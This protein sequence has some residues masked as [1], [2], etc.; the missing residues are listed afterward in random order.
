MTEESLGAG[1]SSRSGTEVL[2]R[3]QE[4]LNAKFCEFQMQ[5]RI[6]QEHVATTHLPVN[7]SIAENALVAYSS[8]IAS[9]MQRARDELRRGWDIDDGVR[10]EHDTLCFC[11]AVWELV[12]EIA[13]KHSLLSAP[14]LLQWYKKHYL[15]DEI[16]EWWEKGQKLADD[17]MAL[18]NAH[19]EFSEI[20]CRLAINDCNNEVIKLLRQHKATQ[21]DANKDNLRRVCDYLSNFPS[22]RQ[23]EQ[24]CAS[25]GDFRQVI[26]EIQNSAIVVMDGLPSDH[27]CRKLLQIYAGCAQEKFEEG[28]DVA[29]EWG[30]TWVEDFV[31]AHAWVWPDLRRS[32]LG[33]LLGAI[34]QRRK[35]EEID[36]I[37]R[38]FFSAIGLD[39]PI[40]LKRLASAPDLFP[41]FFV[42]H[43]VD[44]LYFAGRLPLKV[45]VEGFDVAPPRDHHFMA[46]A[47]QLAAG[48]RK[49]QR[50]AIDYLRALS[51]PMALNVLENV[52]D[53]YCA[54]ADSETELDQALEL[55]TNL[56][57]QEGLGVKHCRRKAQ[58][59]RSSNDIRGCIRWACR[60]ESCAGKPSGYYLSEMLDDIIEQ[61]PDGLSRLVDVLAPPDFSEPFEQYPPK[62]LLEMLR[63][64]PGETDSSVP[65][66]SGRLYFYTQYARCQHAR[67]N[68]QPYSAY[69]PT[70]SR[71][72]VA[73]VV[74]PKLASKILEEDIF[75][76]L[77]DAHA[78]PPLAIDDAFKLM[79][80]VQSVSSDPF[81]RAHF[82]MNIEKLHQA[83]A[84]CL[85]RAIIL[86]PSATVPACSSASI[87]DLHGT[88]PQL[89]LVA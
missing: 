81:R 75:P 30:Q 60:S 11:L 49:M 47:K 6:I 80:Y 63:M 32:Q 13:I 66:R 44:V 37:D 55:V 54:Q 34:A 51:S 71:V 29:K 38:V 74:P 73:G 89:G 57:M 20:L 77:A 39:I 45:E 23:L 82:K 36:D 83:M 21:K 76:A 1:E 53:E 88:L 26:V 17:P 62:Y 85:S 46:Y 50:Q 87:D 18:M 28:K 65:T 15:E 8:A 2:Q 79:R 56:G 22:L 10:E 7:S 41:G 69:L 4:R 35:E 43:I 52:V 70:L 58:D 33:E 67:S 59:L 14:A 24:V 78:I 61:S 25:E 31:Y 12:H 64:H 72:L 9:E 48:S 40:L 3:L 68:Q 42:A 19:T 84:G 27:P 5:A 86:S 16:A